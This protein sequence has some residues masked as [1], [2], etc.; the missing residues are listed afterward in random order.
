[1]YPPLKCLFL[2]VFLV[3]SFSCNGEGKFSKKFQL[4]RAFPLSFDEPVDLQPC[5]DGSGRLFVVERRGKIWYFFPS[6]PQK[7]FLFLNIQHQVRSKFQ[8]EGLLGLAFHPRYKTNGYIFLNYTV[9]HPR[10]TLI[11][12]FQMKDTP[13]HARVLSKRILLQFPQPYA[14]HNGGQIAFGPDGYLYI[15]TGDGGWAGDPHNYAQNLQSLLGKIL[16][17]DVQNSTL[18]QPYAIPPDNPF[19][20]HPS[21]RKEIYAYGLRNPWRFSFDS[22]GRLWAADVGQ[23]RIEE[24][25]LIQK[26]KNYGWRIKEGSLNFAPPSQKSK[27]EPLVEPIWQYPHRLGQSITGGFVYEGKKLPSLKGAYIYADYVSGRIWA[28]WYKKNGTIQNRLLLKTNLNISTFG[29][30]HNKELYF[31]DLRSGN[32][33]TLGLD[34]GSLK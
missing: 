18:S 5:P 8:E 25:N 1:M 14:N 28:L 29:V 12:R 26:G 7:K 30:D 27:P 23:N 20:H 6:R 16:R 11:V 33:F 19:V 2:G 34:G 32:I 13:P 4:R 3:F 9:S 31:C 15:A 24:I 22:Q 10:R 21:A 17:I